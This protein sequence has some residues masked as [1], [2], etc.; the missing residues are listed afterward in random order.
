MYLPVSC[1][2]LSP[3]RQM[4]NEYSAYEK[5]LK[6]AD[7]WLANQNLSYDKIE[8]YQALTGKRD[9][10][11]IHEPGLRMVA[12]RILVLEKPITIE[13]AEE[14]RL[15]YCKLTGSR[16]YGSTCKAESAFRG[17]IS[18]LNTPQHLVWLMSGNAKQVSVLLPTI[19]EKYLEKTVKP[20]NLK[21]YISVTYTSE[22]MKWIIASTIFAFGFFVFRMAASYESD[23]EEKPFVTPTETAFS[24]LVLF[25]LAPGFLFFT[26][27]HILTPDGKLARFHLKRLFKLTS[28]KSE[29]EALI[30][31]LT[32]MREMALA[33]ENSDEAVAEI[34]AALERIRTVKN[35]E[36][37]SKMQ[38]EAEEI[39]NLYIGKAEVET[40]LS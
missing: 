6:E 34:D 4:T 9:I 38:G 39:T 19:P 3:E 21:K 14:F 27:L 31:R 24:R 28:F 35:F 5:S 26:A 33:L 36:S 40:H 10:K 16:A 22:W 32:T 37:L 17:A 25:A 11:D 29:H 30:T 20:T 7:N 8:F 13:K 18:I 23:W 15:S 1:T 2:M 12:Q